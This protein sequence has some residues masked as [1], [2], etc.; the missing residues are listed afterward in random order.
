MPTIGKSQSR[1]RRSS[2]V[3]IVAFIKMNTERHK[4]GAHAARHEH[5]NARPSSE[6]EILASTITVARRRFGRLCRFLFSPNSVMRS[7]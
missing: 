3:S 7:A 6:M 1:P 5:T 2:L 4:A